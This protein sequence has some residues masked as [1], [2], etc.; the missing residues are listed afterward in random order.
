MEYNYNKLNTIQNLES[1]EKRIKA[2][3][4]LNKNA[5]ILSTQIL[6]NTTNTIE[7]KNIDYEQLIKSTNKRPKK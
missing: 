3:I 2:N 5:N 1:D 7:A 6:K 4:V